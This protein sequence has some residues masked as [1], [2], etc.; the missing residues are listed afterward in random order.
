MNGSTINN[1]DAGDYCIAS[2][3]RPVMGRAFIHEE[4]ECYMLLRFDTVKAFS[5]VTIPFFYCEA[6]KNVDSPDGWLALHQLILD[7]WEL[8]PMQS[9]EQWE[10]LVRNAPRS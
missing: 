1:L 3:K 8:E 10:E 5:G 9:M 6:V 7:G 2:T 4:I